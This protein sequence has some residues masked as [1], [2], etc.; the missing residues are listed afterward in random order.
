[1]ASGWAH[2]YIHIP[3]CE[4][5]RFQETRLKLGVWPSAPSLTSTYHFV[6]CILTNCGI[7]RLLDYTHA[8]G[9]THISIITFV[10]STITAQ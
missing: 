10:D 9:V 5:R 6:F 2:R 1:M 8:V 7:I 3:T 4:Q